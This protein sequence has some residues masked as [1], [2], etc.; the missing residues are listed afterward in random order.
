M[1]PAAPRDLQFGAT[2]QQPA[3]PAGLFPGRSLGGS[4]MA[5]IVGTQASQYS[6]SQVS[7]SDFGGY[8]DAVINQVK[9]ML[10]KQGVVTY[11]PTGFLYVRD[12]PSRV[13]AI[14]EMFDADN[15]RREEVDL[16]IT[17]IR[18]DYNKDYESGINWT[19]VFKGFQVGNPART[20]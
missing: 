1:R 8:M 17:I 19:K 13:K 5:S 14:E 9:P 10:S 4:Q 11:M 2:G 20:P 6:A 18:I 12:Y 7:I 3:V 15:S 16:K